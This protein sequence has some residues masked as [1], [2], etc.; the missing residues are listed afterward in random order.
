MCLGLQALVCRRSQLQGS[1]RLDPRIGLA[2]N[3]QPQNADYD[4]QGS[5]RGEGHEQLRAQLDGRATDGPDDRVVWSRE[6]AGPQGV[7][8][9]VAEAPFVISHLPPIFWTF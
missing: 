9:G 2:E 4:E 3:P 5:D 8:L 6:V 7:R 1:Q